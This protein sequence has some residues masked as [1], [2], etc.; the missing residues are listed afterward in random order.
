VAALRF[1]VRFLPPT[2]SLYVRATSIW[3]SSREFPPLHRRGPRTSSGRVFFFPACF[4][5]PNPFA[6]PVLSAPAE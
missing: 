4:D 6:A 2:V 5:V 3:F 1:P